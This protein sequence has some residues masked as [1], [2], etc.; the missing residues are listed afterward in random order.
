MSRVTNRQHLLQTASK[1]FALLGRTDCTSE[2][3]CCRCNAPLSVVSTSMYCSP[4]C[5]TCGVSTRTP[6]PSLNKNPRSLG[7]SRPRN[8]ASAATD[9]S[10]RQTCTYS[11]GP[12]VSA[13]ELIGEINLLEGS[14][15][16]I[17]R[18]KT[19]RSCMIKL[20]SC[21]MAHFSMEP[22][23]W[24]M[25]MGALPLAKLSINSSSPSPCTYIRCSISCEGI[26]TCNV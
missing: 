7:I 6:I 12:E 18:P 20:I 2:N 19:R 15:F 9:S 17:T 4:G 1:S 8:R 13:S 24:H 21:S 11:A 25:L 22:Q 26:S 14:T 16:G 23:V 10:L 5:G 3:S